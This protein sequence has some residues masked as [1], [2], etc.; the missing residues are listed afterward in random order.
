MKSLKTFSFISFIPFILIV[1]MSLNI[2]NKDSILKSNLSLQD[3][4][5]WV[6]PPSADALINPVESNEESISKG[7]KIY[8][9]NCRSC[10]GKTGQG[11]G[12]AAED[13][14]TRITDFTDSSFT[15]QSD[16]S[17]FWKI[18]EGKD[19]MDSFKDVLTDKEIWLSVNYIK[20]FSLSSDK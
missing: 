12:A 8:K 11:K 7:K 15:E 19:E 14:E 4:I 1:I 5:K 6:A 3:T 9:S 17:M 10:H 20:T 18:K 13:I 2:D 16:G